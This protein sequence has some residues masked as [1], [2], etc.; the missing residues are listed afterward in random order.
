[1]FPVGTYHRNHEIVSESDDST[2]SEVDF[3]NTH[4][5]INLLEDFTHGSSLWNG[6]VDLPNEMFPWGSEDA[7]ES[8]IRPSI[9]RPISRRPRKK[10][11]YYHPSPICYEK[12]YREYLIASFPNLKILD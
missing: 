6:L 4:P 10:H 11:R 7:E 9:S 5:A 2:D 1:V 12:H 3:S 8:W